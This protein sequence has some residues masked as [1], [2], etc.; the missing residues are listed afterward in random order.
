MQVH[1]M[2]KAA[3]VSYPLALC[4]LVPQ[5]VEHVPGERV[6]WR[7]SRMVKIV[8]W[9]TTHSEP[10]HDSPRSEIDDDGRRSRFGN[11]YGGPLV[12]VSFHITFFITPDDTFRGYLGG[13]GCH[14]CH[15]TEGHNGRI[16]LPRHGE[17]VSPEPGNPDRVGT[18]LFA[19]AADAIRFECTHSK[20]VVF[21]YP[22]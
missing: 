18:E 9:I 15:R 4:L 7:Q 8:G 11:I 17:T 2:L 22:S 10:L 13:L 16:C 3:Y 12:F 19:Q 21:R 1:A 6:T 14:P 5:F 20:S